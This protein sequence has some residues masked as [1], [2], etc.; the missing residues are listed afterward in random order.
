VQAALRAIRARHAEADP[1]ALLPEIHPARLPRHVAIIMDGN[2][3]W[4]EQRGFPRIFGHRNGAAPV[5][6]VLRAAV[7]LGIEAITLYSF[8]AENWKRPAEETRALMALYLEYMAG[9]VDEFMRENIRLRQIGRDVGLPPEVLALRDRVIEQTSRNTGC[10]LV[11]AVNYGSRQEIVDA[12]RRLASRA[13]AGE[14]SPEEIDEA[15]LAAALDT[16]GLP[17]PDLLIRT[18]GDARLSNF[19][20]WQ[21]SYAEL[22]VTPTLWPDFALEHFLAAIRDFVG[23]SRRFGG[24]N[25]PPPAAPPPAAPPAPPAS[26][27]AHPPAPSSPTADRAGRVG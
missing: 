14:L 21:L 5:R 6:T 12:A 15:A 23:R 25:Q 16:A 18:G 11:L 9:Q 1:L 3:R 2:G 8:S 26:P 7:Q 22:H 27:A 4:A 13:V 10:T 20:L 19:L 24:L 17:D